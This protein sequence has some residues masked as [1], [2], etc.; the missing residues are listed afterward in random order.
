MAQYKKEGKNNQGTVPLNIE[1]AKSLL[2]D[3]AP[4]GI[5]ARRLNRLCRCAELA[6]L[7]VKRGNTGEPDVR[8]AELAEMPRALH[9]R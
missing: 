9:Q 6:L 4:M 3:Q 8:V 7:V 1:L 5:R 2:S